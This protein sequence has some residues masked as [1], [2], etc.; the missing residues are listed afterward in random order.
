MCSDM[1][2]PTPRRSLL[3]ATG[4]AVARHLAD[5]ECLYCHFFL[6]LCLFF[7]ALVS[8][9]LNSLINPLSFFFKKKTSFCLSPH[10]R[11]HFIHD[12]SFPLFL[13]FRG[14]FSPR[15]LAPCHIIS[16]ITAPLLASA[17]ASTECCSVQVAFYHVCYVT[18]Y[19]IRRARHAKH[20][21]VQTP[22]K[23]KSSVLH[24]I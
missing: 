17:S 18:E 24:L 10:T 2:A 12:L 11:Y 13:K 9:L 22:I 16:I 20:T 14:T 3:P 19:D 5:G 8:Y 21:W 23:S 7:V 4:H 15:R 1:N 6:F